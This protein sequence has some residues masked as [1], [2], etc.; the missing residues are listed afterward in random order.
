MAGVRRRGANPGRIQ[1]EMAGIE[2]ASKEFD[3]QHAT[4]LVR[5]L[6]LTRRAPP[7]RVLPSQSMHLW[8]TVSTSRRPHP[9]LFD[10]RSPALGQS[11]EADVTGY[12]GQAATWVAYAAIAYAGA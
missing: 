12:A 11:G 7:D 5:S 9:D 8:P 2:P 3:Q 4:G 6:F 1:V 10:A